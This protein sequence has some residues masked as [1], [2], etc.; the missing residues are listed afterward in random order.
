MA[1]SQP[2]PANSE[3]EE[4]EEEES[5]KLFKTT[6]MQVVEVCHE[7]SDL[8][9]PSM[10][11]DRRRRNF[12]NS[13]VTT[14]LVKFFSWCDALLIAVYLLPF[15]GELKF[16]KVF[17]YLVL[18][19]RWQRQRRRRSRDCFGFRFGGARSAVGRRRSG[20]EGAATTSNTDVTAVGGEGDEGDERRSGY[21]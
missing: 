20:Q 10:Q 11:I 16:L 5:A 18:C 4:E 6:D 19:H 3:E 1:S 7:Q 14:D 21:Q 8:V 15:H 2:E 9:L 17:Q 13:G 12:V